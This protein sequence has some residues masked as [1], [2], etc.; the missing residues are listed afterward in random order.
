M[1]GILRGLV[2]LLGA[3]LAG[4][5]TEPTYIRWIN[6]NG[7]S[8]EEFMRAR[9]ECYQETRATV[10]RAYANQYG[11]AAGSQVIP[12][13]GGFNACLAARGYYQ[14]ADTTDT[15]VFQQPGNFFV[16]QGAIIQCAP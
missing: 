5:A 8:Q 1:G 14:M 7:G 6:Q 15:S 13:C 11:G 12:T 3:A 4:C 16:P 2:L 9:Y 10:S